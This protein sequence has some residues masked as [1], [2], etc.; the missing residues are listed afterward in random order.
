MPGLDLCPTRICR[1]S[2]TLLSEKGNQA[3]APQ[4]RIH[5]GGREVT[6]RPTRTYCIRLP[7]L[8]ARMKQELEMILT[9]RFL[10]GV[11]AAAALAAFASFSPASANSAV[12][13]STESFKAAQ[14]AGSPILVEIHAD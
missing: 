8:S 2:G 9:R 6:F 4:G 14:A 5:L 10:N 7:R 3:A 1:E 12:P 11:I 13:F